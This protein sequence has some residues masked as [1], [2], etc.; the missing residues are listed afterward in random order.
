MWNGTSWMRRFGFGNQW[1]IWMR[2]C[3]SFT[4]FS[5]LVNGSPSRFFQASRRIHQGDPLSPFLFTLVAE[6]RSTLLVRTNDSELFKGFKAR[7]NGKMISHFQF[8]DDTMLFCS[9]SREEVIMLKRILICFQLVS[10]LKVNL[11]KSSLVGVGCSN[12]VVRSLANNIHC[13]VGKLPMLHLGLPIEAKER[14]TALWNPVINRVEKKLSTWKRRYLSFGGRITLIK[15]CLSNLP[16]YYMSLFK[17][18]KS[19]EVK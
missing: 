10:G 17:M 13:K 11:S 3:I 9:A 15:A 14:L 5:V 12:E 6:A 4:S 1:W 8:I 19:N 7:H 2:E 18:P 16:V